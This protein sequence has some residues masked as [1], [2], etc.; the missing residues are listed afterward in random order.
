MNPYC[1]DIILLEVI[2]PPLNLLPFL[3]KNAYF[4]EHISEYC[5][6]TKT[7]TVSIAMTTIN[8]EIW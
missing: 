8:I 7:T 4:C 6:S 5:L 2:L 3:F 1:S